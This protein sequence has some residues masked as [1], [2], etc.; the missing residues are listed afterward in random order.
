MIINVTFL[1]PFV[2]RAHRKVM[3]ARKG[4]KGM[5]I[6]KGLVATHR[7]EGTYLGY[8]VAKENGRRLWEQSCGIM[9]VTREDAQED[10]DILARDIG[11]TLGEWD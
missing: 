1:N 8:V 5:T 3:N 6:I 7:T 10:A 4:E 2:T 9:R 11:A